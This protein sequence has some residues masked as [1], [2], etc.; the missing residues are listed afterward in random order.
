MKYKFQSWCAPEPTS[1]V[2]IGFR[3]K[4]LRISKAIRLNCL[5]GPWCFQL[6][7]RLVD[8]KYL[9]SGQP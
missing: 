3:F 8:K 1:V 6:G 7:A 5:I 9:E 2:G 4:Y